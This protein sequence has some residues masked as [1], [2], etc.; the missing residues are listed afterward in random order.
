MAD[1][2]D[3]I[4]GAVFSSHAGTLHIQQSADNTNWDIDDTVAVTANTPVKFNQSL[5]F[6]FIRLTYNNG[7]T[8]QTAFRCFARFTSAGDS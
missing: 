4:S 7:A 8:P 2:A 1:R 6:P 3:N 5:Y